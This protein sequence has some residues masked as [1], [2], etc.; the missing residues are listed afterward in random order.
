VRALL[1]LLGLIFLLPALILFT[2]YAMSGGSDCAVSADDC[3]KISA[4]LGFAALLFV[5]LS[6]ASF[7][8]ASAGGKSNDSTNELE[9][10][11]TK[12]ELE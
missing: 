11:M 6:V 10:R 2:L 1:N 3:K 7:W 12:K 4:A 5:A 9:G 8:K